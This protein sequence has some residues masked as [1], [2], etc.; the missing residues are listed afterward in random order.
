MRT[1]AL[2]ELLGALPRGEQDAYL[3]ELRELL[4]PSNEAR[5]L[6]VITMVGAR[7]MTPLF[8]EKALEASRAHKAAR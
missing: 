4:E 7:E 2:L 3:A 6:V 8:F 5:G 1:T